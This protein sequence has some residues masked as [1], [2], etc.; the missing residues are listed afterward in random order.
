MLNFC[1]YLTYL[2]FRRR[3]RRRLDRGREY[4]RYQER[5]T[6]DLTNIN[7]GDLHQIHIMRHNSYS[8]DVV[9]EDHSDLFNNQNDEST[10]GIF[11]KSESV[12]STD[13]D[14]ILLFPDASKSSAGMMEKTCP[15]SEITGVQAEEKSISEK[16]A[17]LKSLE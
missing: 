2:Y 15:S 11:V 12:A 9:N 17:L 7:S 14:S 13:T 4:S 10:K 16:L 5:R 6:S 3:R 8:D 1:E